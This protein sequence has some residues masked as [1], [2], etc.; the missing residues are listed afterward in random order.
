[1][2]KSKAAKFRA[3]RKRKGIAYWKRALKYHKK[4]K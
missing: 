3:S 4:R 1:M 2:S